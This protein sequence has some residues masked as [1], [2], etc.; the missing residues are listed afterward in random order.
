MSLKG[1]TEKRAAGLRRAAALIGSALGLGGIA[2]YES[3]PAAGDPSISNWQVDK[4]RLALAYAKARLRANLPSIE[5]E[6][7]LDRVRIP[8]W[9]VNEKAIPLLDFIPS[10]VA[11]PESGQKQL[12]T[13][14]SLSP[15]NRHLHKHQ[16]NWLM[17]MDKYTPTQ[18]TM[19]KIKQLPEGATA[20]REALEAEL[21]QGLKH[22]VDEGIPGYM[23]YVKGRITK[24]PPMDS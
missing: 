9:A 7:G 24:R 18:V 12:K 2:G 23:D 20:E 3:R 14:R 22:M 6:S 10:M 8:R 4:T 16:K 19:Y 5:M 21:A 17:H 15:D 1:T 13:Y 11:V